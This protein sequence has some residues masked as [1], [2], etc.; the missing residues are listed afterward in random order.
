M[1][2][3]SQS[4][5]CFSFL[6]KMIV[7]VFVMLVVSSID[8]MAQTQTGGTGSVNAQLVTF[9]NDVLLPLLSVVMHIVMVVGLA[10][11][12]VYAAMGNPRW[13]SFIFGA[14][15]A[16]VIWYGGGLILG[17]VWAGFAS[18]YTIQ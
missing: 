7:L 8:L 10:G 5:H 6:S 18:D 11:A 3:A 2:Y 17:D 13:K 9:F 4:S 15:I 12:A 16:V 14:L 1:N